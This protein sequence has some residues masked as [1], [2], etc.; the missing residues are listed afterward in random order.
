MT[1]AEQQDNV[2]ENKAAG[3]DNIQLLK[4]QSLGV[5]S[6]GKVCKVKCDGLLCAAKIIHETLLD[7]MD[8]HQ[9]QISP[10]REHRQVMRRFEQ[11]C[12]FMSAVKH[13]NI[14]QFLGM[15]QDPDTQLPV[16]LM[17]LM[18]DNLTHFLESST[19]PIPYH[20]QVNICH[21]ITLALSFLHSN[22][23]VH[24]DLS[25]RNILLI[26]NFRAKVTDFGM[27]RLGLNTRATRTLYHTTCPGANI[28]MPPEAMDENPVYTE[29]IDCFSFG[30]IV[31]QI[32]T[33]LFPTPSDRLV[34]INDPRYPNEIKMCIPE[35][36]RRHTH[37]S[38]IP[39]NHCLRPIAL[40]CLKDKGSERSSAKQLCERVAAL[41]EGP[42]YNESV[43]GEERVAEQDSIVERDGPVGHYQDHDR[44]S[45]ESC[46]SEKDQIIDSKDR[47][48]TQLN[49]EV[50]QKDQAI[51]EKEQ[52]IQQLRQELQQLNAQ[53]GQAAYGLRV[54]QNLQ[55]SVQSYEIR[56]AE[57]DQTIERKDLIIAQNNRTL[58][59]KEREVQHLRQQLGERV[60]VITGKDQQL[61]QLR[62]QLEMSEE[63]TAQFQR[64]ID[65]LE[66]RNDELVRRNDELAQRNEL[67][68]QRS[69][70]NQ[71]QPRVMLPSETSSGM[72]RRP[73]INLRWRAG[74]SAPCKMT[75][76]CDAVVHGAVV[77]IRR[78]DTNKIYAYDTTNMRWEQLPDSL[79]R[80][81]SI[82]VINGLL[83]TVGGYQNGYSGELFSLP[84]RGWNRKWTREFPR[85]PT[86]R[87]G[88]TAL[89]TGTVLVVAGGEGEGGTKLSEVEV[90]RGGVWSTAAPLPEPLHCA[91]ATICNAHIY[92]VGGMKDFSASKSVYTCSLDALLQSCQQ[93]WFGGV[94]SNVRVAD[95]PVIHSTC[96]SL[97]G[98]LLAIGGE[99]TNSL[100]TTAIHMYNPSTNSWNVISHMTTSRNDCYAAVLPDN[101]LMVVGG[102]VDKLNPT[103]S[104]E[105]AFV[106]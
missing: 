106:L 86:K 97:H 32:L 59:E 104:V 1:M 36:E 37:I 41:K 72:E 20:I 31:V 58:H 33:R 69:Q 44:R 75:R 10:R 71:P 92:I 64:R 6:Y 93:R 42:E 79:N 85:M 74:E 9:H 49:V 88:T 25:G 39:P 48:I 2:T 68:Q 73:N 45:Y 13:P 43:V 84:L 15:C 103:D 4:H 98:R 77:Y 89:W 11:E 96:V 7:S 29:K 12:E 34:T 81:C 38:L 99:D 50:R 27:A 60:Q 52:E 5:G 40:D 3:F 53:L 23:I 61:G 100:P 95:L 26:S 35:I 55:E 91:S 22:N 17:E 102:F 18:D 101:Q 19:Q 76:W 47:I 83:T 30:V 65:E 24:R 57:K 54:G 46:L 78:D 28:Y 14:V 87:S 21:D 105:L 8:P 82:A 16:L 94:W 67:E 80:D 56:L 66:H 90:M 62:Q 70:R 51:Q 63:V